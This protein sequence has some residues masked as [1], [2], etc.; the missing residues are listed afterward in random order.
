MPRY[1][2]QRECPRL[3][4]M[5]GDAQRRPGIELCLKESDALE[6]KKC[7]KH[8]TVRPQCLTFPKAQLDSEGVGRSVGAWGWGW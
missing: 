1:H 3:H 5:P 7:D 6:T 8:Y 4:S 2:G